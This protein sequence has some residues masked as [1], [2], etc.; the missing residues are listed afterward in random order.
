MQHPPTTISARDFIDPARPQT[1]WAAARAAPVLDAGGDVVLSFAGVREV[2]SPYFNVILL[3]L[4]DHVP[5]DQLESRV[6]FET[7]AKALRWLLDGSLRAV[8][9]SRRRAG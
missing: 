9:A 4:L 7:D 1:D 6:R 3:G 8:L 5:A 2:A